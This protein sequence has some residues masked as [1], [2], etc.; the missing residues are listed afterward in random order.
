MPIQVLLADDQPVVRAGIRAIMKEAPDIEVVG[1]T[2][3][4][5]EAQ[6]LTGELRPDVMLLR[7]GLP[8]PPASELVRWVRHHC[9]QTATLVETG[10]DRDAFLAEMV[11]AGAAGFITRDEAAPALVGAIRRAA[12]GEVLYTEEQLARVDRWRRDVGR[13]W[14]RLTE[15]EQEVLR[16]LTEG[17]SNAAIAEELSVTVRTAEC[18]VTAILRKLGRA[19]RL[20][21]VVWAREHLPDQLWKPTE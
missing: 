8:G 18:H 13:R 5:M 9:P 3:D 14:E 11:A 10:H 21:T 6:H 2:E 17:R 1:E 4:G 16:L 19:S 12:R 20:E 7:L 15:R